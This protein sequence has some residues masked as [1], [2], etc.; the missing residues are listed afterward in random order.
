MILC[1]VIFAMYLGLTFVFQAYADP[2]TSPYSPGATLNPSCSP[3]S[4][5]CTV[6]PP[7][8]STTTLPTGGLLFVSDASGTIT[9]NALNIFWNAVSS[10]LFVGGSLDVSGT[11]LFEGNLN[12]QTITGGGLTDCE[13]PSTALQ[14]SSSN[15]Q[16]NCGTITAAALPTVETNSTTT[17]IAVGTATTSLKV[18]TSITPSSAS[19]SVL[20]TYSFDIRG[21]GAISTGTLSIFRGANGTTTDNLLSSRIIMNQIANEE[22]QMSITYVDGPATTSQQTYSFFAKANTSGRINI[23]NQTVVLEEI[24]TGS[25]IAETYSTNDENLQPGYVVAVDPENPGYVKESAGAY[26]SNALGIV[27]T[28]PG[29]VM[30]GG[31]PPGPVAVVALAG[32]V[33]VLVNGETGP[34][35]PGD[36]ITSSNIPGYAMKATQPG[37]VLGVAMEGFS[38]TDESTTGEILVFINPHWSLGSLTDLNIIASSSWALENSSTTGSLDQFTAYIQTAVNKLGIAITNGVATIQELIAN[39]IIAHQVTT[40]ML[41]LQGTCI[42]QDQFSNILKATGVGTTGT[43]TDHVATSTDIVPQTFITATSTEA[44]II[45]TATTTDTTTNTTTIDA[46]AE[47]STISVATT[48]DSSDP[49]EIFDIPPPSPPPPAPPSPT[50]SMLEDASTSISTV[51]PVPLTPTPIDTVP[52][53]DTSPADDAPT[54]SST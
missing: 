16:F 32:H 27:S 4:T 26:D 43:S 5:N 12:L 8:F 34:I 7:L 19:S 22:T 11:A 47:T 45:V 46:I 38:G 9:A 49:P 44:N 31:T 40:D 37:R 2:P 6:E 41:C 29:I 15:N 23:L 24:Q 53:D 33:P 10:S 21:G 35:I 17:L 25:D 13:S 54:A 39:T 3:T 52:T 30:G 48:S 42:N 36:L 51:D 50:S 14:W 28:N 18:N 20:V 1:I